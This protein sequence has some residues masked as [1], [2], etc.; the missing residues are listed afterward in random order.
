M[1]RKLVVLLL[2]A[3]LL[4][5]CVALPP[6]YPPETAAP[7]TSMTE[8]GLFQAAEDS[9]NRHAYPQAFEHYNNYLARYPDTPRAMD[10]RLQAAEILGLLG[11]WQ[12]SLRRYQGILTR[13]PEPPVSRKARYG[14]GRAYFRL[15]E[16]QQASQVLNNLTAEDLP[17]S[18]WFSTQT[19][20]AEI[21]LKQ[22]RVSE[23]FNR[24]RLAATD[25][26]VG[27]QE[28]FR[29][30]MTRLLEQAAAP[31]LEQLAALHRDNPLSAA[32][33]LRLAHLAQ[34]AGQSEE[35][36]KWVATLQERFPN[37]AEAA[38]AKRLLGGGKTVLGCL[39]PL[40][41][42]LS[43]IGLRVQRGMELAAKGTSVELVFRDTRADPA[44][45]ASLIRDLAQDERVVAILGP[46]SSSVSQSAADEAQRLSIPLVALAQKDGLTQAGAWIFQAFM[47]PRQQVR[48][49]VRQA[50]SLG[51]KRFAILYPDSAYGRTFR[52]N[53]QT[54]LANQ[55]CEAAAE[56]SY[57][58]DSPEFRPALASLAESLTPSPEGT[59]PATALF[60]PDDAAAAAAIAG[61]LGGT[62][63]KGAQLLGTNLLHNPQISE[64][65]LRALQGII[66]PDAFF[67]A[68]PNP[69]VQKFITAYTQRYGEKPDY[70]A[71]Q[72]FVVVR[73]LGRV[74]ESRQTPSRMAL[75]QQLLTLR[76]LPD[77]PWFQGFNPQRQEETALYLLTLTRAGIQM[78]PA[79]AGGKPQP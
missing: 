24:L 9:Y 5:A 20:L 6:P 64:A 37:S 25:L 44:T 47:T 68:D 22:G 23:A 17:R 14:I 69:E 27:D 32:L 70:L 26:A 49:L 67:A 16:Y 34:D 18:L 46:I 40:S 15:G 79:A 45:A 72:G 13:Q 55:G 52:E 62:P 30:L 58:P 4:P 33:L 29:D 54:E 43:G 78:V 73:V 7:A 71:T 12:G 77:L 59:P 66:F 8:A 63:L 38:N 21:A 19:L 35:A 41:G 36:R 61:A 57:D 65:Q 31:E 74:T 50:I 2:V 56:T 10:A 39:L 1:I 53:Y 76:N 11:D 42:Q 3:A 28:W 48:A 60:I 75:P 51:I